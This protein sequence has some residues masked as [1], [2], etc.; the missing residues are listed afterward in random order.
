MRRVYSGPVV[1]FS[2]VLRVNPQAGFLHKGTAHYLAANP[3][4]LKAS[5]D[6]RQGTT[7]CHLYGDRAGT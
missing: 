7:C 4:N 3:L 6:A 5:R 2:T 1:P